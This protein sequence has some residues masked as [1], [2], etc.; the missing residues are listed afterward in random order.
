MK[1]IIIC[2]DGTGNDLSDDPSNVLRFYRSLHQDESQLLYYDAGV[3]TLPDPSM[4]TDPGKS[5]GK[6]LD[7]AAGYSVKRQVCQ[8]YRFLI[9]H[10][11]PDDK[12]YLIGFSRGA[13]SARAVGG[14]LHLLGLPKPKDAHLDELAWNV[15]ASADFRA[16]KNF[17]F[18]FSR[19]EPV[20]IHFAGVW[21]TVSSF[22]RMTNFKTLPYTSNNESIRHVRHAVA[23]HE[24][25]VCFKPNLFRPKKPDQHESF[26]Q[27][28]FNGVHSDVGG[29][30]PEK[31]AG[32]AKVA[33]KWMYDEA[34]QL[35]CKLDEDQVKFFLGESGSDFF[36]CKPDPNGMIHESLSGFLWKTLE[37]LPRRQWNHDKTP[38]GMSWYPPNLCRGRKIPDDAEYHESVK[39]RQ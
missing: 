13:Y 36:Q 5:I 14:L 27:L 22:G 37:L 10:W 1:N 12:I 39:H 18:T 6:K 31:E 15:Y 3:G 21:D 2:C 29:G 17:R 9:Q 34:R 19:K 35:E 28:W 38:E 20:D 4:L 8:A 11:E 33:L 30:Y 16:G 7:M 23:I 32:L 26:K 25:R 24:R